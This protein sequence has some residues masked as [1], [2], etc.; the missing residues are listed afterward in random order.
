MEEDLLQSILL[1]LDPKDL[2]SLELSCKA[3]RDFMIRTRTWRKK[4]EQDFGTRQ[5][6]KD[7]D[8]KMTGPIS[9]MNCH[10]NQKRIYAEYEEAVAAFQWKKFC[11]SWMTIMT[12]SSMYRFLHPSI[13]EDEDNF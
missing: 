10:V 4:F 13:G 3:F 9:P 11:Q 8:L 7:V 6:L 2:H 12:I 1:Q 5:N